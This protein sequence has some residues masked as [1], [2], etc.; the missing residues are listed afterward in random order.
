MRA[1]RAEAQQGPAINETSNADRRADT[2]KV[3][4]PGFSALIRSAIDNVNELQ[5]TSSKTSND[6][7][8]GKHNDIVKVMV[9]S[10]KSSIGFQAMLQTRNRMVSAYQ[11]IMNM[12]I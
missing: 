10:Q 5:S 12:P 8:A 11:D 6:F 2:G 1:L 9:D 3:D 4:A 7:L